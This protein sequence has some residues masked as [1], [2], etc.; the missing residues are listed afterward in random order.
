[1]YI[2]KFICIQIGPSEQKQTYKQLVC[3]SLWRITSEHGQLETVQ[4]LTANP[5]LLNS[6]K[7]RNAIYGENEKKTVFRADSGQVR[8]QST[9]APCW[10]EPEQRHRTPFFPG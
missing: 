8:T 4:M 10:E 5:N 3:L 2:D 1:M 9:A 7:D 6:A